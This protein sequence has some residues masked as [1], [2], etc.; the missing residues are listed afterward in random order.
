MEKSKFWRC[1]CLFFCVYSLK[2]LFDERYEVTY[3][4]NGR[5]S[6]VQ[7]LFLACGKLNR[8]KLNTTILNLDRLR[9]DL[10]RYFENLD[11][12]HHYRKSNDRG[13]FEKLLSQISS[14]K[15]LI[16]ND[17]LCLTSNEQFVDLDGFSEIL[18]PG[19]MFAFE[20]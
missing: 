19:S 8:F 17:L 10:L 15:Y 5:N 1:M 16:V 20:K 12:N 11:H 6:K 14:R 3:L 7:A 18:S 13:I 2:I 4:S 9:D